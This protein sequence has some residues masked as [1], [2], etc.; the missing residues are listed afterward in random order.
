[1]TIHNKNASCVLTLNYFIKY[2]RRKT[3][4]TVICVD[5]SNTCNKY[6]YF[7]VKYYIKYTC[8]TQNCVKN[9]KLYRKWKRLVIL[10]KKNEMNPA[11]PKI[12]PIRNKIGYFF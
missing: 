6:T 10:K 4:L 3:M 7:H 1:M 8:F 11:S 5:H 9:L 2:F 12:K